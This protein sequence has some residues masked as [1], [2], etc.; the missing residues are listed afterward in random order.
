MKIGERLSR[1]VKVFSS[2]LIT[3][4]LGLE[5]GNVILQGSLFPAWSLVFYLGRVALIGHA[6]ESLIAAVYAPSKGRS[7]LS[8][9]VYTFFVGTI[10][11][12]EL[13]QGPVSQDA[14]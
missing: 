11:L 7:P 5:L 10:G 13:F 2:A 3:G 9:G 6:L 8:I 12:M 1:L 14:Q 4:A